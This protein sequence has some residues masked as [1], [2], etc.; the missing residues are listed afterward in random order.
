MHNNYS[1]F[2]GA[3]GSVL[4]FSN[5]IFEFQLKVYIRVIGKKYRWYIYCIKTS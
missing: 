4:S 5:N 2:K 3:H 1:Y